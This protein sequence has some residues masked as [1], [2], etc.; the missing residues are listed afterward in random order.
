MASIG[1]AASSIASSVT[2]LFSKQQAKR[3]PPSAMR[4][5]AMTMDYVKKAEREIDDD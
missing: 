5:Q 3:A 2:G 1:S 4:S